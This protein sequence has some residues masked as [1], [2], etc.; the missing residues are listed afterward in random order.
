MILTTLLL[1]ASLSAPV[2]EQ[3][4]WRTGSFMSTMG[5]AAQEEK[6]VLIYFWSN[7]SGQCAKL[8]QETLTSSKIVPALD[9]F[10]V[11]S[12]NT[13][14][15]AGYKL[16]EKYGVKTLPTMLVVNPDGKVNDA[17]L[18][19]I[20]VH[21]LIGEIERIERN[22]GTVSALR[23]AADEDPKNME[24]RMKYAIKLGDVG[25]RA[26]YE[27]QREVMFEAD[28]KFKQLATA[29]MRMYQLQDEAGQSEEEIKVADLDPM[30][31]FLTKSKHSEVLFDG[32]N[33]ISQVASYQEKPQEARAAQVALWKHVPE[34]KVARTGNWIAAS[35]YEQREELDKKERKFA[36][37]VAEASFA[38]VQTWSTEEG[39][40]EGC[41]CDG[42]TEGCVGEDGEMLE[43]RELYVARA[44]DTLA[45]AYA[46]NGKKRDAIASIDRGLAIDPENEQLLERKE[47]LTQRG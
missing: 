21:G 13:G 38:S 25:D 15:Q 34:D 45:C 23:A 41:Y 1:S 31:K 11:Y 9:D 43:R 26:G 2:E 44:L 16:V 42:C 4:N 19:F 46:M 37:E 14:E 32:W 24:A 3:L 8:Y 18:G 7:E 39:C 17:I 12:A 20:S 33:W 35:F 6:P 30:R 47:E 22:E 40:G 10:L 36:L 27:A 5:A 29:Q 28:P